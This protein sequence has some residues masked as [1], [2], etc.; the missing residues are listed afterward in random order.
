MINKILSTMDLNG[1]IESYREAF[2]VS[3]QLPLL[4]GY[5][6]EALADTAKIG[7]CFFKGLQAAREGTPVSLSA[8][9]IGCTRASATCLNGCPSLCR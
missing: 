7:G 8:E 3:A 4:F 9:V 5:S 6:D 2:G 1:F